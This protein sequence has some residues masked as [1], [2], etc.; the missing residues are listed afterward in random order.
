M[1]D[2]SATPIADEHCSPTPWSRGHPRQAV[3]DR[4]DDFEKSLDQLIDRFSQL[5]CPG[6]VNSQGP[7]FQSHWAKSNL[8]LL[9]SKVRLPLS[10]I[11]FTVSVTAY[12]TTTTLLSVVFLL[13]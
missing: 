3:L 11:I 5:S 2:I 10:D 8:P 9:T 12:V 6:S 1:T 7:R 13:R 4:I